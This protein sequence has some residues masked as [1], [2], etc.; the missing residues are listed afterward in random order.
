MRRLKL[1]YPT[2]ISSFVLTQYRIVT[3]GRT[4]GEMDGLGMAESRF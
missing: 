4:D 2:F 3:D 1:H